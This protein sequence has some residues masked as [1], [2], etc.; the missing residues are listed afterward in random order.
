[1]KTR[2]ITGF[3]FII[4]MLVSLFSGA[5]VFTGFYILLSLLCL[6][7]FFGLSKNAGVAV[8]RLAGFVIGAFAFGFYAY[9]RFQDVDAK[10]ALLLIPLIALV[11]I[12]ELYRK[13][14]NP[15]SNI[16]YTFLGIIYTVLPFVCYYAIA[17][18]DGSYNYHL[19]LG[20]FLLLWT[21]DTGAYLFGVK[22]GRNKLFERHSPKK[23][24]EGFIGGIVTSAFTAYIVSL[25]FT[26]YSLINWLTM[27]LIISCLGTL[28]DLVESMFKRSINVKDSGSLLPGHG[29]VLDRFDGLLIS[30]PIVFVYLYLITY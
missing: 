15:F 17:F 4:V 3:V 22:L 13:S 8:N 28:A 24:W 6:N 1:M 19:A 23:S 11:F 25:Y 26:E 14:D 16:A 5:Y 7:E 27:S 20:F 29:G 10:Y 12:W 21:S 18:I 9:G 30:A 2:A